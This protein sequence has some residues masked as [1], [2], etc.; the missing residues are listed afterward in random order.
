[1]L[2]YETHTERRYVTV[3]MIKIRRSRVQVNSLSSKL[4]ID[5]RP[6]LPLVITATCLRPT[7]ATAAESPHGVGVVRLDDEREE[8]GILVV[9]PGD[10]VAAQVVLVLVVE[11][12]VRALGAAALVRPEHHV[13]C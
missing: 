12:E 9:R 5:L 13:V 4:K 3:P 2:Q 8:G 11:D 7:L 10:V 6:N 1:M